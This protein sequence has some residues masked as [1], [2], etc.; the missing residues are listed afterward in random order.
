MP[1]RSSHERLAE[2]GEAIAEVVIVSVAGGRS[3]SRPR[4][5]ESNRQSTA[6][7]VHHVQVDVEANRGEV[8]DDDDESDEEGEDVYTEEEVEEEDEDAEAE[9][10][11]NVSEIRA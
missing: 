4:R 11:E 8:V 9:D 3:Q 1:F 2:S 7:D 5:G 6:A 10:E